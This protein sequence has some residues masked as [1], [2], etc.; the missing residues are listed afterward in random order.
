MQSCFFFNAKGGLRCSLGCRNPSVV[1]RFTLTATL[2]PLR[3]VAPIAV[4]SRCW[5]H[6][7]ECHTKA[8]C[9]Q[10]LPHSLSAWRSHLHH[11]RLWSGLCAS[12]FVRVCF[13]GS[14][15]AR[16]M[17]RT[18]CGAGLVGLRWPTRTLPP[19]SG[20]RGSVAALHTRLVC[21]DI[22]CV[23]SGYESTLRITDYP[24]LH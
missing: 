23:R 14:R 6:V 20:A 13:S 18:R 15:R 12:L 10:K 19:R 3:L 16:L 9:P 11:F 8:P 2:A 21:T 17:G 24:H 1:G 22:V 5:L 4:I 7:P